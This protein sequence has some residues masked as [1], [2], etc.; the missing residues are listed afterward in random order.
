MGDA[1]HVSPAGD[2]AMPGGKGRSD[3]DELRLAHGGWE[4][5]IRPPAPPPRAG[6]LEVPAV[7]I[8]PAVRPLGRLGVRVLR[9]LARWPRGRAKNVEIADALTE[10]EGGK[11]KTILGDMVER[12]WLESGHGGYALR[13][14]EGV[15]PDDYRASLLDWLARSFP[16]IGE[17]GSPSDVTEHPTI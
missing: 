4:V 11:L 14:P 6:P 13:L 16:E 9:L 12:G 10:S 5:T 2:T 1:Q 17:E 15:G 7:P 3:D 8:Q